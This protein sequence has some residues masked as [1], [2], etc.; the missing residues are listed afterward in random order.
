MIYNNLA[1]HNVTE[2]TPVGQGTAVQLCRIP[3]EL[4]LQL[5]PFAHD[6]G[7]KTGGVE[8]RF[9][10][11]TD[12]VTLHLEVLNAGQLTSEHTVA[13][14]YHGTFQETSPRILGTHVTEI[15]IER[16]GELA[17]MKQIADEERLVFAPDLV[18]VILPYESQIAFVRVEGETEPPRACSVP[19]K[20]LLV[21]GSS[22]SNGASAVRPTGSYAMRTAA[23]L[24]VDLLNVSFAG[25]AM[26]DAVMADYLAALSNWHAAFI[27]LGINMIW[28]VGQG[29]PGSPDEFRERVDYFISRVADAHPDKWIFCTDLF[30]FKG[31]VSQGEDRLAFRSAV[32]DKVKQM[33]RSKLVYIPGT[34]LLTRASLLTSDLIH[35][36]EE[37]LMEISDR[38][39]DIIR[40]YGSFE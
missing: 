24:Q 5:H 1:F 7:L 13:Q 22:I 40:M 9:H 14:V 11:I 12:R 28:D 15:V 10:M 20:R 26:V 25:G 39:M 31:D 27:E 21:Y 16:P 36:S 30:T 32:A 19:D 6:S 2:L 23:G 17:L 37:G 34:D 3:T 8:I 38:L 35:P 33:N 18:R 4:R 29:R